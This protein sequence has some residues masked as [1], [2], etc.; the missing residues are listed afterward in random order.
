MCNSY[1]LFKGMRYYEGTFRKVLEGNV[2]KTVCPCSTFQGYMLPN[3]TN[4]GV[5]V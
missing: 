1:C 2:R 4:A 3:L 5:V